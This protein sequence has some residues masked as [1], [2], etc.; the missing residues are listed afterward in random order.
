MSRLVGCKT[1]CCYKWAE[2]R[3]KNILKMRDFNE[4][5]LGSG[6]LKFLWNIIMKGLLDSGYLHLELKGKDENKT[7]LLNTVICQRTCE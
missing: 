4:L 6:S 3:K 1:G 2:S 7:K 5:S